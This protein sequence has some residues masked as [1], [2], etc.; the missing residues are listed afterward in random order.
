LQPASAAREAHLTVSFLAVKPFEFFIF[1]ELSTGRGSF[2]AARFSTGARCEGGAY[3]CLVSG[4][5][6]PSRI[7]FRVRLAVGKHG[8]FFATRKAVFV[9]TASICK[10]LNAA[11][12]NFF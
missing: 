11:T 10:C 7:F 3:Y 12:K 5:Q 8:Y 6:H 1:E 4:R 2:S 9:A